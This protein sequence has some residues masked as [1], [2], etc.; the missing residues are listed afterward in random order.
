MTVKEVLKDFWSMWE[1]KLGVFCLGL[2]AVMLLIHH[3]S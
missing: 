1:V 3:L 2:S